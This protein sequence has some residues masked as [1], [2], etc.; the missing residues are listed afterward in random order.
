MA[1]DLFTRLNHLDRLVAWTQSGRKYDPK[2]HPEYPGTYYFHAEV[3]IFRLV[4]YDKK[5]ELK[6][7]DLSEE[8]RR[9]LDKC[10]ITRIE[11]RFKDTS[12]I[13]SMEELATHCFTDLIPRRI[14]FL[15][16]DD[17]KLSKHGIKPSHY[18]DTGLNGLRKLLKGKDVEH[19][20]FYYTKE[21]SHL[22][23]IVK[24]ALQKYRWC[25]SPHDY[26]VVQPKMVIRPQGI[27]FKQQ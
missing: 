16:P 9:E 5:K 23:T 3:S 12:E 20:L 21:N 26:P 22:S 24:A 11:A 17:T 15:T 2:E 13:P 7:E 25:E 14:E 18:R 8:T 1:I 10:N 6:N 19:N 27:K 4:A